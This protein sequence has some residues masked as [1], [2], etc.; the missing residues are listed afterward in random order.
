MAKYCS[1]VGTLYGIISPIGQWLQ[2]NGVGR[3]LVGIGS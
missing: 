1:K 2:Y 3:E